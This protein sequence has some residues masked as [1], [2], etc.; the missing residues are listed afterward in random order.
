MT[1]Q[2]VVADTDPALGCCR[3]LPAFE[4]STVL[5]LARKGEIPCA[6][7]RLVRR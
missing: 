7:L 5:L 4:G 6:R 2:L 1:S 3:W